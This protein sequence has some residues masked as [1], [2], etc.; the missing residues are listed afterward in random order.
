MQ[1]LQLKFSQETNKLITSE[2]NINIYIYIYISVTESTSSNSSTSTTSTNIYIY[3]YVPLYS[4]TNKETKPFCKFF[5]FLAIYFPFFFSLT[6][7][8]PFISF[9]C[10]KLWIFEDRKKYLQNK[11]KKNQ[12]TIFLNYHIS[13]VCLSV[14][15]ILVK[16]KIR[17]PI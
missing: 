10:F 14:L 17:R 13:P 5:F 1:D 11:K 3:K 8:Q 2:K 7:I 16:K 4:Q 15:S 6:I 12:E 9:T